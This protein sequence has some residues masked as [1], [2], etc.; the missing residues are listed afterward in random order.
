MAH[1][2]DLRIVKT[3]AALTDAFFE[4]LSVMSLDD[5]TVNALCDNAG[6]RRATF[7]KHFN[8]KN[9]FIIFII[10]DVREKFDNGIWNQEHDVI[11]K[12]YYIQYAKAVIAF[13][14]EHE[15]AITRLV[16]S[17]AR[18]TFI[19]VFM[20]QNYKDTKKRLDK[21]EKSGVKL[22]SSPKVVARMIIGGV[23][24]CIIHW[25]AEENRCAPE[26]LLEDISN[27]ISKLID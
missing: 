8:D 1:K 5:I 23:S 27:F 20:H 15:A 26:E 4:M 7:Y 9:D 14:L 17:P 22:L 25:F 2:E 11:T 12:D 19:D 13:L 6:V 16:N 21:S 3:K 18:S 10:K 24:H